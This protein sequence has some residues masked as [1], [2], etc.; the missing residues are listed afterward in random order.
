MSD[1]VGTCG[2]VIRSGATSRRITRLVVPR[3]NCVFDS[4]GDDAHVEVHTDGTLYKFSV[5]ANGLVRELP[6]WKTWL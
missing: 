3:A 5:N 6:E 1:E 2:V 4:I